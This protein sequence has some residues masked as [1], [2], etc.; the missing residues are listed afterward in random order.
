MIPSYWMIHLLHNEWNY[1]ILTV[2]M[3][4]ILA[5]ELLLNMVKILGVLN[6]D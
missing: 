4:S 3:D 5:H 2:T 6:M 1:V